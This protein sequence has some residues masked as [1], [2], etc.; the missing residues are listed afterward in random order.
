MVA[1]LSGGLVK[2]IAVVFTSLV[3]PV[4]V[5]VAVREIHTDEAV[6]AVPLAPPVAASTM[7]SEVTHVIAE[8]VGG[9]PDAA[10]EQALRT[11]LHEALVA[12][13]DAKALT[14]AGPALAEAFWLDRALLIRSCKD[15]S[16]SIGWGLFGKTYRR[17]VAV[18]FDRHALVQ[19]LHAALGTGTTSAPED[20]RR[21]SSVAPSAYP[22]L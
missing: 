12:E 22:F 7:P 6:P 17:Q 1:K 5:S 13:V 3:A 8:G 11:A 15:L 4:I 18:E 9:S 20:W 14:R 10:L 2:T 16:T 21:C 19:R